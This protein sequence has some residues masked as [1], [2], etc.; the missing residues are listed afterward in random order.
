MKFSIRFTV[1]EA[2]VGHVLAALNSHEGVVFDHLAIEPLPEFKALPKPAA[3]K[4]KP[5]MSRNPPVKLRAMEQVMQIMGDGADYR[6]SDLEHRLK[7]LGFKGLGSTMRNLEIK[8]LVEK[9]GVQGRWRIK[10]QAAEG[11]R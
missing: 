5:P 10:A 8:G 4:A 6:F 11:A 2:A 3:P 7:A 1:D 9:T